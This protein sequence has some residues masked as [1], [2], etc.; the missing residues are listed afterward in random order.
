MS[1]DS[2]DSAS[3]FSSFPSEEEVVEEESVVGVDDDDTASR[4]SGTAKPIRT[5]P[6]GTGFTS[7]KGP[8]IP[9]TTKIIELRSPAPGEEDYRRST[10]QMTIYEY[11]RLIGARAEMISKN[12]PIYPKYRN[13]KTINLCAIAKMELDDTDIPF[14]IEI[15]RFVDRPAAVDSK[16]REIFNARE[17][18]LPDTVLTVGILDYLPKMTWTVDSQL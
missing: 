17:L 11:T 14:P 9:K 1:S 10:R 13:V 4:R 18:E 6:I 8:G 7:G 3:D 16:V 12:E 15:V 5:P 2:S